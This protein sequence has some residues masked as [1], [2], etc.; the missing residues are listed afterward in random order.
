MRDRMGIVRETVSDIPDYGS[1]YLRERGKVYGDTETSVNEYGGFNDQDADRLPLLSS[2]EDGSAAP[3]STCFFHSGKLYILGLEGWEELGGGGDASGDSP[4]A[5]V[6][7]HSVT[8]L[9]SKFARSVA[10]EFFSGNAVVE[11]VD[12][13]NAVSIGVRAFYA[14]AELTNADFPSARS[15]GTSAFSNCLVLTDVDIPAAAS[16]GDSAFNTCWAMTTADF[17]VAESIGT[18]AFNNCRAL[19][20]V[21]FPVTESIG[22]YAFC[23]CISLTAVDFPAVTSI[24]NHAFA[25][26]TAL[27]TVI[28]RSEEI[29]SLQDSTVFGGT[30]IKDGTGYIYVPD[31]LV[32]E[33]KAA[34]NWNTIAEQ[35]KGISELPT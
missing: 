5:G 16:I 3:G 8:K 6:I 30:P 7:E 19:T 12:L 15:I 18:S 21:N 20:S 9:H 35:I 24:G 1:L 28:L 26:C 25:A 27:T 14:C 17:P 23:G 13:P 11:E 22:A 2:G 32:D 10:K 33:Y 31:N 4:L 29:V 34:Q